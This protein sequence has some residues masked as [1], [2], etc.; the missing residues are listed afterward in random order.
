METVLNGRWKFVKDGERVGEEDDMIKL[1]MR[2]LLGLF[3]LP[4]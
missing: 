3:R 2:S 1:D 4:I